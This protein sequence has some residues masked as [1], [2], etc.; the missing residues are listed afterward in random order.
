[1]GEIEGRE[2]VVEDSKQDTEAKSLLKK[3]AGGDKEGF[4]TFVA[5]YQK[6]VLRIA[7]YHVG[8]WQDAEDIAQNAFIRVFRNAKKFIGTAKVS[9]WLFRIVVNLCHDFHRK[10]KWTKWYSLSQDPDSN[11]API[12]VY[13]PMGPRDEI[14]NKEIMNAIDTCVEALPKQQKT[15]FYLHYIE[16]KKLSEI[17]EILDRTEGNVKANLFQARKKIKESLKESGIY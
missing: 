6:D 17:A 13:D 1:M 8:N 14:K 4:V 16:G 2:I 15:V 5:L 3:I 12:E 10:K 11:T 9:T 7:Y